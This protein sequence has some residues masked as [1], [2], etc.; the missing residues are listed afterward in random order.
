[1]RGAG[2]IPPRRAGKHVSE[3]RVQL[4]ERNNRTTLSEEEE[5]S[6]SIRYPC[7]IPDRFR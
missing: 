5:N 7:W 2:S 6:E 3:E 4:H 1:M